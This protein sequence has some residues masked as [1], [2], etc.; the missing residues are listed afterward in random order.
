[1]VSVRNGSAT[2]TATAWA[3]SWERPPTARL[4]GLATDRFGYPGSFYEI[5]FG[6]NYKYQPT[7]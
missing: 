4:R 3:A 1:M 7:P 5:T 6:A 2:R